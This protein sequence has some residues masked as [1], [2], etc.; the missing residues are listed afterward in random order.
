MKT[1]S[2]LLLIIQ[3][4]LVGPFVH[5]ANGDCP[6]TSGNIT[7]I[8]MVPHER[9]GEDAEDSEPS[10]AVNFANPFDLV[11]TAFT[12]EPMGSNAPIYYSTDG[13]ATWY[14][15]PILMGN[16]PTSGTNDVSVS[17]GGMSGNLYAAIIKAGS[18]KTMHLL[19]T[20][21]FQSA[22]PM[23]DVMVPRD[24]SD[25]PHVIAVTAWGGPKTGSDLVYVTSKNFT[26][27]Q[28]TS[29]L[30]QSD[31][32]PLPSTA[33]FKKLLL[34][35]VKECNEDGIAVL[36]APQLSG[37]V[38]AACI[39]WKA[40][41]GESPHK[42]DLIVLRDDDWGV[43][44]DP[45]RVLT[46]IVTGTE[47]RGAVAVQD[48]LDL[49][50]VISFQRIVSRIAIAVSPKNHDHVFLM[51]GEG[52]TSLDYTLH[53]ARSTDGG[54]NW[55]TSGLPTIS[56][57]TNPALAVNIHGVI[58]FVYQQ[59]HVTSPIVKTWDTHFVTS[60]DNLSTLSS[61][62]VLASVPDYGAIINSPGPLGDYLQLVAVGK[63][64]YGV[65]SSRNRP[66]CK[67]F[68]SGVAYQ[69]YVNWDTHRLLKLG[70]NPW[71]TSPTD[72]IPVST[73]P[74]FFKAMTIPSESDFYVR[75]WTVSA[76]LADP[77]LEPSA[78]RAFYTTSDVW[79][80][81]SDDPGPFIDDQPQN[82]DAASG[83]GALANNWAFARIRRNAAPTSGST[84]VTA[85]F[86]VSKFGTGSNFVDAS[87]AD[88]DVT[89][90][91]PPDPT[92]TFHANEL[93]PFVT[94]SYPWHLSLESSHLCL[95]VEIS[96]PDDPYVSPSLQGNTPGWSSLTDLRVMYD[97]NRAQR[98]LQTLSMAMAAQ[99]SMKASAYAI[100]H[101]SATFRR[102]ITLR[103]E[104]PADV[105]R[106]LP[107]V[108]IE[109][110]GQRPRPFRS[111]ESV[112]L[113]NME[114]GENRWVSLTSTK[115]STG[116]ARDS[117]PRQPGNSLFPVYFYEMLG[118][119][120]LNGFAIG[121]Q[122]VPAQELY[123]ENLLQHAA[124]LGRPLLR[125]F[126][127]RRLPLADARTSEGYLHFLEEFL[128][129]WN[130]QAPRFLDS[131]DLGDPFQLRR[132]GKALAQAVDRRDAPSAATLH[133]TFLN[134][135]D[136]FVTM[137]ELSRGDLADIL[138]NVRWQ[139][140]MFHK[141]SGLG[142]AGCRD[143][144]LTLS[145]TFIR[146][147]SAR[148]IGNDGYS[149]H[150]RAV[151]PCL[152]STATSGGR[153]SRSLQEACDRMQRNLADPRA[154]QR[155]HRDYLLELGELTP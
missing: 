123:P 150:I 108:S 151:L 93:G 4:S 17:F 42:A 3:S 136:S 126:P 116:T 94:P 70:A 35:E 122:A 8:N 142:S 59:Y 91:A 95:A 124:V 85:H 64:F 63:N 154:L 97:N 149:D 76:L 9:S 90:P 47:V 115:P 15:N 127:N 130:A 43:G 96:S 105:V 75:D 20:S 68:P 141:N 1:R 144:I 128:T 46:R 28:Q 132:A 48:F 33:N 13:G 117:I 56:R 100:V 77:G 129:A 89:F 24:L 119:E 65:F 23:Q 120:P 131:L 81:R 69:R 10:L 125:S 134:R 147:Y 7:V 78:Q 101:N 118:T 14:L 30:D 137:V 92:V 66:D 39:R 41:C 40:P 19:F 67:N 57:A 104:A 139:D 88:P 86:L 107:N 102:D 155:A 73:D 55:T 34:Q 29:T 143:S 99:Q 32:T 152:R 58:G 80:R 25:Q 45:F 135:L 22:P 44:S 140:A 38:Y 52:H 50:S 36:S 111:G 112:V 31:G 103:Y 133:L 62:D 16:E 51:W 79:N 84:T 72:T 87:S 27:V 138:Q 113:R 37:R 153:H 145:K 54:V 6:P 60:R 18:N 74:F 49:D 71:S 148:V 2:L 5:P 146:D 61:D 26:S 21:D 121:V 53:M 114:P 11:G 12:P 110:L 109:V 82:E 106:A 98:N 83:S